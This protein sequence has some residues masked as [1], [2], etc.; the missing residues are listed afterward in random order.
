M[1]ILRI[2]LLGVA[3]A[4]VFTI[5]ADARSKGHH[6]HHRSSATTPTQKDI[7]MTDPDKW[8]TG[9]FPITDDQQI[10]GCTAIINSRRKKDQR[11]TAY[12]N[13]GN[14]YFSKDDLSSAISDYTSAL[15][16]RTDY[17]EAVYNRAVAYRAT[18]N[19]AMAIIDYTRVLMA[20]PGDVSALTG[21]GTAYG[22][23]GDNAHAIQ[24]LTRAISLGT[25]DVTARLQRGHAYLR[26]QRWPE[27]IADYDQ[28]LAAAPS[29]PEAF[30]GRACAKLYSGDKKSGMQDLTQAYLLDQSILETMVAQGIPSPVMVKPQEGTELQSTSDATVTAPPSAGSAAQAP[31]PTDSSS[32]SASSSDAPASTANTSAPDTSTPPA[33]SSDSGDGHTDHAERN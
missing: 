10:R 17:I 18:K 26:L 32:S 30:F 2:A 24:D 8:C 3:L 12:Y 4:A 27:A 29:N 6:R 20:T 19:Y 9:G 14:A 5:A 13:R 23:K 7:P 28:V 21:R 1:R 31:K 22:K 11:A 25:R 15:E 16:I 33:Q